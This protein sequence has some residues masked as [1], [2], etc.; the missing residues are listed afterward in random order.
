MKNLLSRFEQRHIGWIAVLSLLALG[1]IQGFSKGWDI[2]VLVFSVIAVALILTLAIKSGG[3]DDS[4]LAQIKQMGKAILDGDT[5][6]RIVGIPPHHPLAELA[7]MLNEG[8][9]QILAFSHET[10]MSFRAVEQDKYYRFPMS[11]GLQ[12]QYKDIL[13]RITASQ[14]AMH[15][16]YMTKVKEKFVSD[17]NEQKTS[18][19]L[20][21]LGLMQADLA[22]ITEVMVKMEQDTEDSVRIATQGQASVT[23]VTQNLGQLINLINEVHAS[24]LQ[25]NKHSEDVSEIL[26]VIASIAD[27]TNL[28]ALNAAIEAARAGE[29][30]R[31]FAVVADEVKKLSENTKEATGNVETVI[32]DF[33]R[34]SKQMIENAETISTMADQS[35]ELINNFQNDFS[36]FRDVAL[37]THA[38]VGTTQ[39]VSNTSLSKVDHMIYVQNGY[40]AFE[41]GPESEQWQ[42]V[43]VDHENC[44]FGKWLKDGVGGSSYSHLPS[45]SKIDI[46]HKTVHESIHNG[47]GV[48]T[49]DWRCE[50]DLQYEILCHF[51]VAEKASSELIEIL[52]TLADEKNR[53]D[54]VSNADA[55]ADIELF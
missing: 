23:N 39:S 1:L 34:S 46:P 11:A 43:M 8:R 30:G 3:S 53:F 36:R 27:Q 9:D 32:R 42:K 38:I 29:H 2:P 37:Q 7:W 10:N 5:S 52:T 21:N 54:N 35:N 26:K 19:L 6:F 13:E 31:G 4:M 20:H 25:L 40:R 49:G 18:N 33:T 45:F 48:A 12:G 17:M 28:L 51:G 16:N 15:E 24:S 50:P 14:K 55:E 47:L 44:R 41:L 22:K